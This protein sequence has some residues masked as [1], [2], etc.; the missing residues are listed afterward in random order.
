MPG[1]PSRHHH[2]L[3]LIA[4]CVLVACRAPAAR[5]A[6]E[7]AHPEPQVKLTHD[8]DHYVLDNGLIAV[9]LPAAAGNLA[10]PIAGVRLPD[11]AWTASSRW[12][13]T[14]PFN[15]LNP[16]IEGDGTSFARVLLRYIFNDPNY[17]GPRV[18]FSYIAITLKLGQR[19]VEIEESFELTDGSTWLLEFGRG[20]HTSGAAARPGEPITLAD[21]KHRLTITPMQMEKWVNPDENFIRVRPG[22]SIELPANEGGR[23]W[24]LSTDVARASS[25]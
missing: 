10:G 16:V 21:D 11:G 5:I 7:P 24:R 13:T 1:R 22:G 8:G 14:C 25:P 3:S 6:H 9:K 18:P 23:V 20:F 2:A 12:Q 4:V 19:A 17:G 15:S